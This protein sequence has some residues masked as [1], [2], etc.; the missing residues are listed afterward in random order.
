[1]ENL[2]A[3]F[4]AEN[5]D[6]M[7]PEISFTLEDETCEGGELETEEEEELGESFK[8]AIKDQSVK[9]KVNYIM[10]S[11]SFSML[12]VQSEDSG[13]IWETVSSSRCSTPWASESTASDVYSV[14]GTSTGALPGKVIFI[15]DELPQSPC[16][17]ERQ[18][19][20]TEKR[21]I[22]TANLKSGELKDAPTKPRNSLSVLR[23]QPGKNEPTVI[24]NTATEKVSK[25]R[26]L[27]DSNKTQPELQS[28]IEHSPTPS[29]IAGKSNKD[30]NEVCEVFSSVQESVQQYTP[31]HSQRKC[32]KN[33]IERSK[34]RM[35]L[36]NHSLNNSFSAQPEQ[37]INTSSVLPRKKEESGTASKHFSE[38]RMSSAPP[39]NKGESRLS[40]TIVSEPAMVPQAPCTDAANLLSADTEITTNGAI[41][42]GT[43]VLKKTALVAG[44]DIHRSPSP[45]IIISD[46]KSLAFDTDPI[47][48][49][50]KDNSYFNESPAGK[51]FVKEDQSYSMAD[52][53]GKDPNTFV[54]SSSELANPVGSLPSAV[55]CKDTDNSMSAIKDE[56]ME[57]GDLK[58]LSCASA[59]RTFADTVLPYW[60][61]KQ[62][63]AMSKNLF[64]PMANPEFSEVIDVELNGSLLS[65]TCRD[66]KAASQSQ[67]V[68]L[69]NIGDELNHKEGTENQ[70]ASFNI[71]AEGSEILNIVAPAQIC[72]VDQETCSKM[73][74]NL[75]YLQTNPILKRNSLENNFNRVED[76][77]QTRSLDASKHNELEQIANPSNPWSSNPFTVGKSNPPSVVHSNP[78]HA[79]GSNLSLAAAF[80]PSHV[81]GSDPSHAAAFNP[82]HVAGSDPSH[83]AAFNPSHAVRS[84]PSLAAAFNPSHAVRSNPSQPTAF[85]P[86]HAVGSNPSLAA[87]FNPFH[88]VGSDPSHAAAFNPSHAVGSDP[89]HAAA[90]N[91]SHAVGSDPSH[92]AAFNPSHAV[93][94]DPSHAP[95]FNPSHAVG[96]HPSHAAAFNPSHAVGSDPSHAAAF[97]PSHA[98]RSD[99]SHAA[100][101][102]PSHAV[103]SHPSHAAAFNPSHAVGSDPSHAA[104]FN[105][106]HAVGSHP[107]HAAAFNPSHAV[108]S[109]PSHA[110]AFNPSHAVES[111]PSHAAAFNSSHADGTNPYHAASFNPSHA[112][113]SNPYHA[114]AFNPSHAIGSNASQ[115]VTSNPPMVGTVNPFVVEGS[116]PS[117]IEQSPEVAAS[118][119]KGGNGDDDYFEKYTLVD[120]N[121]PVDLETVERKSQEVLIPEVY[122]PSESKLQSTSFSEDIE[123]FNF[124]EFDVSGN[125]GT[126]DDAT[127]FSV[128]APISEPCN[129][130]KQEDINKNMTYALNQK[131]AG[132]LLFD[133]DEGVL[134]R[135]YNFPTSTKLID[136]A[137][138]EEPPALAFYYKDLYEEAKG[139]KEQNGEQSDEESSN[140]EFSFP[141]QSSDTDDGNG[142]YFEKYV[143]RDDVLESSR[144][145][146]PEGS[147]SWLEAMSPNDA[148]G[149]ER[150]VL[151]SES[152]GQFP[153]M[154]MGRAEIPTQ[155]MDSDKVLEIQ[156]ECEEKRETGE[157]IYEGSNVLS[158]I[159]SVNYEEIEEPSQAIE[160]LEENNNELVCEEIQNRKVALFEETLV[161]DIEKPASNVEN[162]LDTG[163]LA[164]I[165]YSFEEYGNLP[166][167]AGLEEVSNTSTSVKIKDIQ[168]DVFQGETPLDQ[169][170]ADVLEQEQTAEQEC[171]PEVGHHLA[172]LQQETEH[173]GSGE[174]IKAENNV[175]DQT[176]NIE[177]IVEIDEIIPRIVI[178]EYEEVDHSEKVDQ[179]ACT[180]ALKG[181]TDFADHLELT[182]SPGTS[183]ELEML[184]VEIMY[185]PGTECM[186][187]EEVNLENQEQAKALDVASSQIM[188]DTTISRP[189]NYEA[190]VDPAKEKQE[191]ECLTGN[192]VQP[193]QSECEPL[194]VATQETL[195]A[196]FTCEYKT[197]T[198]QDSQTHRKASE[199]ENNET[200]T[201]Q[202]HYPQEIAPC[203]VDETDLH[204]DPENLFGKAMEESSDWPLLE[205]VKIIDDGDA[206]EIC[207]GGL[208]I[209][210]QELQELAEDKLEGTHG[211]ARKGGEDVAVLTSQKPPKPTDTFCITCGLPIF[212]IDKLFGEHQDHDVI[213]IDT[214][215]VKVKEKLD[216]C[217]EAAEERAN[218]TEEFVT[219]LEDI[220]NVVEE[221]CT[222]EERCLEEE[223]EEVMKLLLSQ[224]TEMSQVLE[225]E[226]K[227]KLEHLYDQMAHYRCGID[228]AKEAVEKAKT[229]FQ[230]DDIT[231][232]KSFRMTNDS[233]ISALEA[234]I[235]MDL[236]PSWCSSLEDLAVKSA[237]PGFES[238]KN[239]PVPQSPTIVPQEPNT[240]TS[241]TITV[242]WTVGKEDVID[243]FQVYCM[244]ESEG[245]RE[246]SGSIA[247]EYKMAVKESYCTLDNLE[248]NR[249]Y[250]VWVMAVNFAGCSLPSE[251]VVVQTV[252]S[253]PIIN[254]EECTEC[255][256]S[257]TIRWISADLEAVEYF[258]LEFHRQSD[259]KKSTFRSI[260]GIRGCELTVRLQPQEK[261]LFFV[262]TVNTLGTSDTSKPAVISTKNTRFQLNKETVPPH[263]QLSEDGT[264]IH[265]DELAVENESLLT[266]CSAVL[267]EPLP[268]RGRLYWEAIVDRCEAY[269]IG[270]AN[271]ITTRSSSLGKNRTSW[272]MRYY[273]TPAGRHMYEFLHNG[274]SHDVLITDFPARVGVF[275]NC[276]IGQLSFFNAQSGQLLH[277]FQHQFTGFVCPAF[278]IEQPGFL[279]VCTG[280]EL[281]EFAKCS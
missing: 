251:K 92:A 110:P 280:T 154:F 220:F 273:A 111:H 16:A 176:S 252:P 72:S 113:G 86:S 249:C 200:D 164:N 181:I 233:V 267:G 206:F 189:D 260:A 8:D 4:P 62:E 32:N 201:A 177:S 75:I 141:C 49:P 98:V 38:E 146:K 236:K 222:K 187:K 208:D 106:S 118:A 80:N 213:A 6:K 152:D 31:V 167:E 149:V 66:L 238:L 129:E 12:T 132:S 228:S 64:Y 65:K 114:A 99:P 77:E 165:G 257:A 94:S 22:E 180:G 173:E 223:H 138:L 15:M 121:V 11:S 148:I 119:S 155:K 83:A 140:P 82:S 105:P 19:S 74:D 254:I 147:P 248:P 71:V 85:N 42:T 278:V 57:T 10:S 137:L 18:G 258:I 209:E 53:E 270:V 68:E 33:P 29:K 48:V 134:T 144:E 221:N 242:Y 216:E 76:E 95:A 203:Q 28:P 157:N 160:L 139:R 198:E 30:G 255:W 54:T 205:D 268:A 266:E 191:G 52:L 199:P 39:E 91:P 172:E 36:K 51:T 136:I 171:R 259:F 115:E 67:V 153:Q 56:G 185:P 123:V 272:C 174:S 14:D 230:L 217:V 50:L 175:P 60:P 158:D 195:N 196:I 93:G 150:H 79:A 276:D 112:V 263:L 126:L 100:A 78:S 44:S 117:S 214:A 24:F 186:A 109:D 264:V 218:R 23:A 1:M 182:E 45:E 281:P 69:Q 183:D 9:P 274:A 13:I 46:F 253:A 131:E 168:E 235:S 207:D 204:E 135:S 88:A 47:P 197:E 97:N 269:R 265:F 59:G 55:T 102:N 81:A 243:Y 73:K 240:A 275:V 224:Y 169:I 143:L 25:S 179:E 227:M 212:A 7:E 202:Q 245:N 103:G 159:R 210:D 40:A 27:Q 247:D 120:E 116:N 194:E 225:E 193:P 58:N 61:E 84:N 184:A 192:S 127:G 250:L 262:K 37:Q 96:S 215:V 234:A 277:T 87:A 219:E 161:E 232:L 26:P 34:K 108:G 17:N 35:N 166:S 178:E 241:T 163:Q 279:T 5:P 107:S 231:F 190:I 104:A 145:S 142:L 229:C 70:K 211:E 125:P 256:D 271:S 130:G 188:N 43:D 63:A 239:L 122:N 170:K 21:H 246:Q 89:S 41:H 133:M 226:K 244:E 237:R 156:K 151:F 20:K 90:F 128:L 124:D 162:H 101:F 2:E 261:F 3:C